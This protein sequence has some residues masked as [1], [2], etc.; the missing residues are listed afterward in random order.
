MPRL[1]LPLAV[2]PGAKL[3]L[4]VTAAH[5]LRE[6]LRLREGDLLTVF[7]GTGSEHYAEVSLCTREGVEVVVGEPTPALRESPLTI[8]LAQGLARGE[9]MDYTLQKAVE[10]GV[11]Q[12]VPLASERS[13]VKLDAVRA[14]RRL[15]HWRAIIIHACEQSGR[16]RVPELSEVVGLAEFIAMDRAEARLT[17][18]PSGGASLQSLPANLRSYSLVIGPEGGLSGNELA[19]LGA[20]GYQ[21]IRLGP[22]TL[23]TETAALV[24]LAALQAL[25]GDLL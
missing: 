23:R 18:A 14:A 13:Q 10:L 9:R 21:S 7:D 12:I 5:R 15:E 4:P 3:E 2:H 16:T 19:L 6:V 17:L 8:V 11:T 24:A 20:H 22:R 1:F 25:R